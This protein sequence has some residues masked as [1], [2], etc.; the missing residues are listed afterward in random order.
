M[1]FCKVMYVNVFFVCLESA[2]RM[3]SPSTRD[4][5]LLVLFGTQ[6]G[7]SEEF[8]WR[9][10]REAHARGFMPVCMPMDAYDLQ[11]LPSERLLVCIASTTGDGEPPCTMVQTWAALRR[12]DLPSSALLGLRFAVFGCGD[13]SYPKF[14]IA[15]R[16]LDLRSC[17]SPLLPR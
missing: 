4:N 6:T 2:Y 7:T 14:N 9:L 15:A 8:A 3:P 10:S 17:A 12:R 11:Q 5:R 13:S 1:F 16:R